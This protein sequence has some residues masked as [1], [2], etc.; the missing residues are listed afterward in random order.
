MDLEEYTSAA[1]K[2][3]STLSEFK[4]NEN[5]LLSI[6]EVLISTGNMLDMVKK[7]IFYGKEIDSNKFFEYSQKTLESLHSIE[8]YSVGSKLP[9]EQNTLSVQQND[10]DPRVAHGIIGIHTESTELLEA[11]Y[12][13]LTTGKLDAVNTA[14]E[15]GDISWYTAILLDSIGQDWD[16][17]MNTNLKKLKARY[18]DSFESDNAINRDIELERK[19]LEEK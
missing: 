14:E 13:K 12:A 6:L 18:G 3:E 1:I 4:T 5:R 19:I 10:I 8:I 2:T 11:L 15:I 17:V 16:K 7:N 9:K